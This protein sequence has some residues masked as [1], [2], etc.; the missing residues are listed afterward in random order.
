MVA[1]PRACVVITIWFDVCL[2]F[3]ILHPIAVSDSHFVC[4]HLVC[5]IRP[6]CVYSFCANADPCTV[7]E[8]DPVAG[9]FGFAV[10]LM[11]PK[12]ML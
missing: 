1:P 11:I 5:P 9:L 7:M 4:S 10:A 3:V 6:C 12:F 2:E 8:V